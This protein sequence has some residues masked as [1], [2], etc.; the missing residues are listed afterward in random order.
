MAGRAR[1]HVGAPV[2]SDAHGRR[3]GAHPA[4]RHRGRLGEEADPDADQ[5]SLRRATPRCCS[6]SSSY[7]IFSAACSRLAAAVIWSYTTS[8]RHR[9]R[10]VSSSRITLRRRSSS[11]SMPSR[12]ARHVHHL[13]ARD[14]LEHP[15][16]AVRPTPGVF[17]CTVRDDAPNAGTRYGPGNII[18]VENTAG[19]PERRRERARALE[20]VDLRRRG[21]CRPRRRPWSRSPGRRARGR[22]TSRFSRR[23][24][25]H[26]T[27]RPSR[28]VASTTAS[29]SGGG[30]SSTRMRRRRRA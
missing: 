17:V 15:R 29:S 24:W 26:F 7:P 30:S 5:A 22:R 27:G 3:V 23:S 9:V 4:E 8:A 25:I 10:H 18:V 21:S 11:G 12:A 14:R 20:E 6:R 16:P 19:A 28:R 13:L 1:E 2:R